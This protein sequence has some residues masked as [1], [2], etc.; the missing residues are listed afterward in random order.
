MHRE[1]TT[2][3]LAAGL[4]AAPTA[5]QVIPLIPYARTMDLLVVDSTYDGIWRC[6]DWN[7]DGDL[8]DANEVFS[9]YSDVLGSIVLGNPSCISTA[10][11]GTVYIGDSTEDVIVALRDNNEDGDANDP[12]EHRV[13]F[14]ASN[15]SGVVMAS[16]GGLYVD[17]LGRVF[18]A[19]ANTST[20]GND[21]ILILEDLN[22][23][24]D[25]N[26]LGEAREYHTVPGTVGIGDSIP[27]EVLAGPDLNL[28]YAEAGATG[29]ITKGVYRLV[30]AN[31]DGDCNDPGERSLFWDTTT[32]GG[33]S[34]FHYGMAIDAGGRFFISDH[35]T[36][37]RILTAFDADASGV[38]DASEATVFYQTGASTWWDIVVRD[39]YTVIL[40]EDQTPDRLTALR[41]LNN[42]G[43][44]MD[45]GEAIEI[46]DETMASNPNLRPRGA[47][48]MRA[49]LLSAA[50]ASVQFGSSTNLQAQT[51]K[52]GELAAVF[53]SIGIAP[54]VSVV[55]FGNV[56]INV[57]AYIPL[58]FGLSDTSGVF[59]QPFLVPNTPSAIGTYA[60]Q[61]FCGDS[62]RLFLSNATLLTVTP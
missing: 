27:T 54:P 50:P 17:A 13:F 23:D 59:V 7:Q 1:L 15:Q 52:P 45:P 20:S 32:L 57:L 53:L 40:C 61:A 35:S 8:L 38:I 19:V 11:D 49:P 41:D 55:P 14:D 37:E 30:D 42:D 16:V 9:Y 44:A 18:V 58:G 25:A 62:F 34:P 39:D 46:Y 26:D 60:A 28:Y 36:N 22:G 31:F 6:V 21:A 43:D 10:N 47:A 51:N 2:S 48:W 5:A 3:L 33:S 24:G 12:G 56:E 4:L 29:V